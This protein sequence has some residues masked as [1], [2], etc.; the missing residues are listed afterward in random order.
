MKVPGLMLLFA[1]WLLVV[2]ALIVL[3]GAAARA[4]FILAGLLV[5]LLGLVLFIRGQFLSREVSR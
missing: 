4:A 3:P 5:E 2:A 1:G